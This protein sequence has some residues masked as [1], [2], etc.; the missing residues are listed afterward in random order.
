[1]LGYLPQQMPALLRMLKQ[2]LNEALSAVGLGEQ[3]AAVLH[4]CLQVR[5]RQWW[6]AAL[7]PAAHNGVSAVHAVLS[8]YRC[9]VASFC[10]AWPCLDVMLHATFCLVLVMN[11]ACRASSSACTRALQAED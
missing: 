1:M 9:G 4:E 10:G 5:L 7:W 2:H 3:D 11:S 6:Q 8:L